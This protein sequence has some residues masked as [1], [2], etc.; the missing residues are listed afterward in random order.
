MLRLIALSVALSLS[1][2]RTTFADDSAAGAPQPL[3]GLREA[4]RVTVDE[5]G[6]AHVRAHNDHDLYFMQ[7]WVHTG[8][9]LFQMDYNRRL[10]SG[11]VAELLGTAA[12]PTDVQ[13]RTL[14][15]RRSAQRSYDA[16]SPFYRAALDAYTEGVNARLAVLTAL[17]PEYGAVH[18][19]KVAP[20][21]P[22]DSVRR[23]EADCLL[24]R[25]RARHRQHARPAGVY[26]ANTVL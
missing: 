25:L 19:T 10:A 9:R 22:V 2:A 1:V 8:E 20:W 26:R 21:T 16:A 5:E 7:G 13:L 18:L 23:R 11:T 4:A 12:S 3:A 14:G 15:L 24:E 17:P 6:I